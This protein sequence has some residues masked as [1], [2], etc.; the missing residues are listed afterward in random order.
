MALNIKDEQAHQL[1][2]ELAA[3]T[4]E[5]MTKAVT[6]AIRERLQRVRRRHRE[7]PSVQELLEYGRRCRSYLK[8]PVPDHA[9]LLY[10]KK[11]M[12]K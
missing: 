1:A 12:P 8:G 6:E 9:K 10:D 5:S 4:G 11:G 3:E 7:K 2:Q